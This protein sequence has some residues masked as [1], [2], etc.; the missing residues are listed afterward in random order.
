MGISYRLKS[1]FENREENLKKSINSFENA[2]RNLSYDENPEL[3]N[4]IEEQLKQLWRS[5]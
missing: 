4:N 3:Y 2:M 5:Y 1:T